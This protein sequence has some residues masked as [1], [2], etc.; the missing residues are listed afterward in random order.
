MNKTLRNA[1][2]IFELQELEV[3][4]ATKLVYYRFNY[5]KLLLTFKATFICE[6]TLLKYSKN[7]IFFTNKYKNLL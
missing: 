1:A 4:D 7:F 6:I 5:L 2:C 3:S